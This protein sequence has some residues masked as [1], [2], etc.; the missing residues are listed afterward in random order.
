MLILRNVAFTESCLEPN[1][2]LDL[3]SPPDPFLIEPLRSPALRLLMQLKLE[4]E[5]GGTLAVAAGIR[6]CKGQ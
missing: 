3:S 4:P 6:A 2:S 5:T 1:D